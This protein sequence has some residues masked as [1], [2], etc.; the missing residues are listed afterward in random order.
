[1]AN[2]IL[3][4]IVIL[5]ALA[6]QA[7]AGYNVWEIEQHVSADRG[8]ADTFERQARQMTLGL[9]DLRAA[10][11]AY[12]ADG[13]NAAFWEKT[14]TD[15]LQTATS[16]AASLRAAARSPEAQGAIE[17]AVELLGALG[18]TDGR[19]TNYL[20][21]SQR[22]S[23]SDVVFG[24]ATP[25]AIRAASAIDLA[26]GHEGV[27]RAG[28]FERLRLTQVYWL[29]GAV[30]VTLIGL[31]LLFPVPRAAA[32]DVVPALDGETET[33]VASLGIAHTSP[34]S[35]PTAASG[36]TADP[37]PNY[38]ATADLCVSLARVKE[39]G[40]F[41]D[42]LN[43]AADV[44][45]AVGIIIWMPDGPAGTL[46]PAVAHGYAP[47]AITRMGNIPIDA[48]N[49]TALAFRS[50]ATEVVSAEGEA[51]G[52]VVAPLVTAD[53]CSGVM[54][55]EFRRGI[56]PTGNVRAVATIIAAQMATLISPATLPGDTA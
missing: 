7:G 51:G 29:A 1:M 14:A 21:S 34:T 18:K 52:A 44:L 26:R 47:I 16:Q 56:T 13:Q 11:Q 12:V 37:G 3:R 22:L 48:D 41:P 15:L 35:Q 46:R 2:R 31:I 4:A 23:A 49:A 32:D 42:L 24:E 6:A 36:G 27:S 45:D 28:T 30:A 53:G 38:I 50:H 40:E 55:A 10:F 5:V 20:M 33:A 25:Q 8:A 39:P 43:R 17:D 9:A 54:A 19:A